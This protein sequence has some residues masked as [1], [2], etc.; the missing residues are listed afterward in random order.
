MFILTTNKN[1][2]AKNR[3]KDFVVEEE[4]KPRRE[5]GEAFL[6]HLTFSNI[7]KVK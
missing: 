4:R 3:N 2:N 7:P 5:T 1:R 6:F